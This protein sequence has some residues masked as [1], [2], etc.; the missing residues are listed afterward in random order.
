MANTNK[1]SFVTTSIPGILADSRKVLNLPDHEYHS[2]VHIQSCSMLKQMLI[3]PAHY[4]H[5]LGRVNSPTDSMEF[6]T[7]VHLLT[8]QPHLL[9]SQV[10]TFPGVKDARSAM[11]KE[12]STAHAGMMVFDEPTM[13]LAEAAR[14]RL[15]EQTVMGRKFGDFVAE[16]EAEASIY[17][18]D[19]SV[20]IPCRTRV[21]L[22][23]PEAVFDLKTTM[24]PALRQW[25]RHALNLSYDMQGYMYS[26]AESLLNNRSS[27]IPFVFMSVEN[28][29]PLSVGA[30]RAGDAFMQEGAK[31]YQQAISAFAACAKVDFWPT[32]GGEEVI[33]LEYW[34]TGRGDSL[35][36]LASIQDRT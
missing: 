21:D 22:L 19:P 1:P 11:Y 16:G 30:R 26:L 3:S 13:H 12:F 28:D 10:A 20:G 8:L 6:G 18:T 25:T 9:L 2:D 4:R 7:L 24:H 27:P 36:W 23:H 5:S 29:W 31:K 32:P 15:L 14:D 17:Y 34:Q 33:E 35:D